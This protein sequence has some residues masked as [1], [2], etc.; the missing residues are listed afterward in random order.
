MKLTI[1]GCHSAT[2][3][4]N[5]RPT[6]Q[7]LEI[8]GHLILI[9]CGEG[10]QMA[11]RKQRVKFARV[12]HIFISHLHGDHVYGLIGL[13]STFCL[14][15]REQPL[16]VYGPKGIQEMIELQLKLGNSYMPFELHF[17]ELEATKSVQI[18][19]D[20]SITVSTIPLDHRVYTNGYL[21]KEK[22]NERH[23]DIVACEELNIEKA[24]YRK[25][26]QGA[27]YVRENGEV[28]PNERLTTDGDPAK[29]YAFCSD[30]MYKEDIITHIKGA[31]AL[32]HESTFLKQHEDLC[33]K[34][35]HSTAAQA[36]TIAKKADVGM[37]ILGHYSS[38]YK[39]YD[40]FTDEAR[41][42][43]ENSHCALDGKVFEI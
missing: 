40:M 10:T 14:L 18:F 23:L 25:I 33:K 9:D 35:K 12:K 21:F 13:I 1:L 42:I 19:E 26:K 38:R 11:L 39:S 7:V 4:D 8:K 16:H 36:A 27:D 22:P 28:I 37:L 31:T 6:A 20:D 15:G 3:R 43:F 34:T 30:T 17:T 32:Y 41:P 2:P 5:A 29:S 24:Y